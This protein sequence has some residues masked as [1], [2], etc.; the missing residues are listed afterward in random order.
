MAGVSYCKTSTSPTWMHT[1]SSSELQ[2]HLY[3]KRLAA[4]LIA[5]ITACS[6]R[7]GAAPILLSCHGEP[8]TDTAVVASLCEALEAEL[9]ERKP[10]DVILRSSKPDKLPRRVWD[11][12]LEVTL[13]ENY[14]WEG[15]LTWAKSGRSKDGE[16]TTGPTV[17][18]FGM[19]APLG[20]GAYSH[21]TRSLL[22][23]GKPD[24]LA[25]PRNV[26]GPFQGVP[27]SSK[28]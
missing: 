16:R 15:Y 25:P 10:G 12:V 11:V 5:G 19:D 21:F 26:E 23:V 14:H 1:T 4:L 28:N 22:K 3:S 20:Q 6:A 13:T 2:K 9:V 17:E 24:F 27:G 7:A 18:I 8:K